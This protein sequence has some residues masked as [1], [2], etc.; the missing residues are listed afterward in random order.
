MR[1]LTGLEERVSYVHFWLE[2]LLRGCWSGWVGGFSEPVTTTR[3]PQSS[4]GAPLPPLLL[5]TS[6]TSHP[7]TS[8]EGMM[9]GFS[10]LSGFFKEGDAF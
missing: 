5:A 4:K 6:S 8:G 2:L 3:S 7:L 9:S 10:G 1:P